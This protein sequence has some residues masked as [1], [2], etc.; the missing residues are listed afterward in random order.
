[1][2]GVGLVPAQDA[3]QEFK[4]NTNAVS[5]EFGRFGGGVIEM[6]TKSGANAFHG[7]A[8]EYIRNTLMNANY[9]FTKNQGLARAPFHQNQYG[10]VFS[11]PIKRDKAFFLFTWENYKFTTATP[12]P[13]NVPTQAMRNGVFNTAIKD[14]SG[15]CTILKDTP[16]IGQYTIP[17]TCFDATS[18][19]MMNYFPL[20]NSTANPSFNYAASPGIGRV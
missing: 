8:Y 10:V 17:A 18:K 2:G 6:T 9:F 5:A 11:G 19:V 4:V 12:N 3:V 7:S 16:T 1:M 13:T 14:P 20:P 15:K